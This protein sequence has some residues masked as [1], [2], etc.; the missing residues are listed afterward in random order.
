MEGPKNL[1]QLIIKLNQKLTKEIRSIFLV[2]CFRNNLSLLEKLQ[3]KTDVIS[4][5]S[6]LLES[7]LV[8]E[9]N[10][11]Y[12]LEEILESDEDS[13][14]LIFQLLLQYQLNS[15]ALHNNSDIRRRMEKFAFK[16]IQ[17][18]KIKYSLIFLEQKK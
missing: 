13:L 8:S 14:E 15:Q 12:L 10:V 17:V 11:C 9:G 3:E 4:L 2:I 18:C 6:S 5:S 7:G 16:L 1:S